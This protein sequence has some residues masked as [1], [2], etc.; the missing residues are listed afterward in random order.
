MA[1]R[2]NNT[3]SNVIDT[4]SENWHDLAEHLQAKVNKR[5]SE[6][7]FLQTKAG[8][9]IAASA[10][11]LQMITSQKKFDSILEICLLIAAALITVCSLIISIISMH[12]GKSATPLNP[13]DMILRLTG[14]TAMTRKVFSNWI[15]NSYAKTNTKFNEVYNKKYKQQM[16]SA[17]LIVV[18]FILLVVL[19]GVELYV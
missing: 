4:D 12:V 1:S 2:Q 5:T 15:A 7:V 6:V 11:A 19:K 16:V 8:F 3:T 17:I 18:A 9:L 13:D 10:I 14:D